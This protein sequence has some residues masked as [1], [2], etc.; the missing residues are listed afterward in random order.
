MTDELLTG[1]VW[2]ALLLTFGNIGPIGSSSV[3]E[4]I[5]AAPEAS[6]GINHDRLDDNQGEEEEHMRGAGKPPTEA[7]AGYIVS[8]R[9]NILCGG[10]LPEKLAAEA[11][12]AETP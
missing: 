9:C 5:A 3:S 4:M 8:D 2:S 11:A 7:S 1:D 6:D 12:D 10:L